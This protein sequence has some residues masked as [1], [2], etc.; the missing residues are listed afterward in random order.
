MWGDVRPLR[1]RE[2]PVARS[3]QATRRG[4]LTGAR[5]GL[6]VY[7]EACDRSVS[8]KFLWRKLSPS[9]NGM[10]GGRGTEYTII[11]RANHDY[12]SLTVR[13]MVKYPLSVRVRR[14]AVITVNDRR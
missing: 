13:L 5:K 2:D 9:M 10:C 1:Q 12:I 14:K 6:H 4:P 8:G 7:G 11:G 3:V